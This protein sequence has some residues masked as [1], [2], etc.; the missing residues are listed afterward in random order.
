M[1]SD[2]IAGWSQTESEML[3]YKKVFACGAYTHA[4]E[5]N[6]IR[7]HILN[8]NIKL[9]V[10]DKLRDMRILSRYCWTDTFKI[11]EKR[12]ITHVA[13]GDIIMLLSQL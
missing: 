11:R 12:Y 7:Y 1:W 10:I 2:H 4:V 5:R 3:R 9:L 13:S 8:L 6:T